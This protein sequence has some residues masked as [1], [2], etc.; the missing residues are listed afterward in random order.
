MNKRLYL[1]LRDE[2]SYK[3]SITNDLIGDSKRCYL[4]PDMALGYRNQEVSTKVVRN[5][6]ALV[7]FRYDREKVVSDGDAQAVREFLWSLGFDTTDTTTVYQHGIEKK[8]RQAKVKAKIK[9]YRLAKLVVTDRLHSMVFAAIAG[10]PCVAFDNKTRKVSGVY[11][12]M[13]HLTYIKIARNIEDA[14]SEIKSL[15]SSDSN[16]TYYFDKNIFN[17]IINL[18]Q[19]CK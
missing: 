9:E 7:C 17:T 6:T 19:G 3:Y 2:A 16:Y 14:K 4:L 11:S 13:R 10:T 18:V 8:D 1:C 5:N 12:W 15:L